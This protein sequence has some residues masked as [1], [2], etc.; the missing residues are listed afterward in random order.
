MV[1]VGSFSFSGSFDLLTLP[2]LM[3]SAEDASSLAST[4]M[5]RNGDAE[6]GVT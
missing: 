2:V 6:I 3:P 1:V 5:T 4:T